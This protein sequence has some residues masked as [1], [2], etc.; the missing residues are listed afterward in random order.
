MTS[1]VQAAL[2]AAAA[3]PAGV[4]RPNFLRLLDAAAFDE[5]AAGTAS[6]ARALSPLREEEIAELQDVPFHAS[7]SPP[8]APDA[9]ERSAERPAN[10]PSFFELLDYVHERENAATP[11][12]ELAPPAAAAAPPGR[13]APPAP[14]APRE[15]PRSLVYSDSGS[16][17]EEDEISGSR[18]LG[19]D[20]TWAGDESRPFWHQISGR[21]RNRRREQRSAEPRGLPPAV[22]Q[23]VPCWA[24]RG[25]ADGQCLI[26]ISDFE[27]GDRVRGLPCLHIYHQ[28]CIDSWFGRS[29][30]CPL[31][32]REVAAG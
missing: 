18:V 26:C 1:R 13:A 24:S 10:A 15:P 19:L 32:K 25:R 4:P 9:P 27:P 12:G 30:L 2:A 8:R 20:S 16:D 31:C 6:P 5:P 14:A 29:K 7:F 21:N 23:Q 11:A 22:L 17:E 28:A 3:A